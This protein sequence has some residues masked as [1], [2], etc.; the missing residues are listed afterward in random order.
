M[1]GL[2]K[3]AL[4]GCPFPMGASLVERNQASLSSSAAAASLVVNFAVFSSAPYVVEYFSAP[5]KQHFPKTSF[6]TV[7]SFSRLP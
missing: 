3:P 4:S 6:V 5:F 7:R 1:E 2:F